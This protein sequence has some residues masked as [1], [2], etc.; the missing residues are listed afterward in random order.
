MTATFDGELTAPGTTGLGSE[1]VVHGMLATLAEVLDRLD[2]RLAGLETAVARQGAEHRT[3]EDA[4]GDRLR[5]PLAAIEARLGEVEARVARPDT[6]AL[7]TQL[8]AVVD[9]VAHLH[10]AV[11]RSRGEATVAVEQVGDSLVERLTGLE[12]ALA[13]F[14]AVRLHGTDDM[15]GLEDVLERLARLESLMQ[16][17]LSDQEARG[18]RLAAEVQSVLGS[19]M[20]RLLTHAGAADELRSSDLRSSLQRLTEVASAVDGIGTAVTEVHE[21]LARLTAEERMRP[22]V[23]AL[24]TT[25]LEQRE[26]MAE[27][28]TALVRRIDGRTSA[29]ARLVDGNGDLV[30]LLQKLGAA[31]DEQDARSRELADAVRGVPGAVEEQ[32]GSLREDLEQTV[33]GLTRRQSATLKLLERLGAELGDEHRRLETVQSL[34]QSVASAVEQQAAVGG[35]VAELVLETRS[36]MRSDV[37]RLESTVQLEAVKGRQQDQARLAQVAAGVT[38]VVEREAALVAQRVAA[39]VGTVESVRAALHT[40]ALPVLED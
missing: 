4:V 29:L 31:L 35:R 38:D 30:P 20:E 24:E 34:C 13:S 3:A 2:S 28:Q 40:Q 22:L 11:N 33:T 9:R 6:S 18:A 7:E 12:G 14:G 32:L 10:E 17:Q 23:N 27:L 16:Q 19:G 25:A 15:P 36:V 1:A 8:A 5:A 21:Q 39:L 37:E 26:S